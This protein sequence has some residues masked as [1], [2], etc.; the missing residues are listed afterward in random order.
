MQR[1]QPL[2]V[3]TPLR[4]CSPAALPRNHHLYSMHTLFRTLLKVCSPPIWVFVCMTVYSCT[5]SRTNI[6]YT[7]LY[8]RR[9]HHCI[10]VNPPLIWEPWTAIQNRRKASRC[11]SLAFETEVLRGI[12]FRSRAGLKSEV[13]ILDIAFGVYNLS[14]ETDQIRL[15]IFRFRTFCTWPVSIMGMNLNCNFSKVCEGNSLYR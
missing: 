3:V 4:T 13:F 5:V 6:T 12:T 1:W 7:S 9:L 10:F 2:P 14:V 15:W 11:Y 8:I